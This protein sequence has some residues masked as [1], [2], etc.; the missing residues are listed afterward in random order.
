M[1]DANEITLKVHNVRHNGA[2]PVT[3]PASVHVRRAFLD[4]TRQ[5]LVRHAVSHV[6][7][8]VLATPALTEEECRNEFVRAAV[9]AFDQ[10]LPLVLRPQ[11]FWLCITQAVAMHINEWAA[12]LGPR[13]MK[14]YT[15]VKK[16]LALNVTHEAVQGFTQTHWEAVAARF[17]AAIAAETKEGVPALLCGSFSASTPA[18]TVASSMVVM[19][20]MKSFF[21]FKMMTMCGFPAIIL[22]G[23]LADW[24]G[25]R[26]QA[27]ALL[28]A[29]A[30]PE[31]ADWWR[32]ILTGTLDRLA[33]A[34]AGTVDTDFWDSFVKCGGTE[35]SGSR[36]WI[37]G[38]V[39]VFFPLWTTDRGKLE[40]NPFCEAY[41]GRRQYA[42][43]VKDHWGNKCPKQK[44]LECADF[45]L[46]LSS[47][48]VTLDNF[49][50]E[51]RGGFVGAALTPGRAI[52]PL[53]GWL[54]AT[55]PEGDKKLQQATA[56]PTNVGEIPLEEF[57][58]ES[59][60]RGLPFF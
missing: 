51:F 25:L 2:L 42:G 28:A 53:V 37:S 10:H 49:P 50:L 54:V 9:T 34:R 11:H 16:E 47:A 22:Q 26:P 19:D 20:A 17:Q 39:N 32:P 48:P 21:S 12:H 52:Q 13:V 56:I 4:R 23:S 14:D 33:A 60:R 1:T 3:E 43:D 44:G 57:A 55:R 15:G 59:A 31:F 46:G 40:R 18:E 27:E 45:P 29:L 41:V 5:K 30:Y 8:A 7:T 58:T 36:S 38:W 24:Q 6:D 35:G